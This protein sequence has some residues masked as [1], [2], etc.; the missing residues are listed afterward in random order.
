MADSATITKP[1]A[2]IRRRGPRANVRIGA[3]VRATRANQLPVRIA[4]R[5]VTGECPDIGDIGDLVRVAVDDGAGFVSGDRDHLRHKAN[6]KLRVA[7]ARVGTDEFGLV[8]R[9]ETGL[10]LVLLTLAILDRG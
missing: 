2:A 9:N 7:V 10:G 3:L 1:S 6:G 5:R 4:R 8:D